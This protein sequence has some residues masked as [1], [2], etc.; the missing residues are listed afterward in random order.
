MLRE[1]EALMAYQAGH[2]PTAQEWCR[3]IV[4]FCIRGVRQGWPYMQGANTGEQQP[5]S[6]RISGREVDADRFQS[7]RLYGPE[8]RSTRGRS[9]DESPG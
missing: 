7:L 8:A 4:N 1:A 3:Q 9:S 6:R 5:V 2:E